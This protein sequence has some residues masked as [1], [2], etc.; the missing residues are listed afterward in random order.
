MAQISCPWC[1]E[2]KSI[3]RS[4]TRWQDLPR[5]LLGKRPYRCRVCGNRFYERAASL[6]VSQKQSTTAKHL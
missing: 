1:S 3:R 5:Y 2:L 6:P 4:H